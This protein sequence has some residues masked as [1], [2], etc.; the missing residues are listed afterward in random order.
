MSWEEDGYFLENEEICFES[1]PWMGDYCYNRRRI[2][3]AANKYVLLDGRELVLPCVRHSSKELHKTL[4]IFK[5]A[6]LLKSGFCAPNNQGFVDQYSNWWSREDAFVIAMAANQV[7]LDRNG[8]DYEL[9]SEGL[10]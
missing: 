4:D 10:Y 7:N 1:L 2:V 3:S 6:G 5:S 9:Y 8:S